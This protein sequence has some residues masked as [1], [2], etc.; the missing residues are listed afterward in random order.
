MINRCWEVDF[1]W[2]TSSVSHTQTILS[3]YQRLIMSYLGISMWFQ[4]QCY[5]SL[6]IHQLTMIDD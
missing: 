5:A 2:I 6:L 4:D 3:H 1:F